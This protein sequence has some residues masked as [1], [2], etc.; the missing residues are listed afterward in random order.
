MILERR[1]KRRGNRFGSNYAI[2]A[3]TFDDVWI[4]H[5][6]PLICLRNQIDGIVRFWNQTKRHV[7]SYNDTFRQN[8]HLFMKHC[9]WSFNYRSTKSGQPKQMVRYL[10]NSK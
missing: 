10:N 6:E 9:E 2:S 8:P 3:S 7:I 4:N 5:S 1:N